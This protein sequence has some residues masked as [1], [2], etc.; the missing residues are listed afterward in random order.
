MTGEYGLQFRIS[1]RHVRRVLSFRKTR[2]L[3]CAP[4]EGLTTS[5]TSCDASQKAYVHF[6]EPNQVR[7]LLNNAL[8]MPSPVML[9]SC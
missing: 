2:E 4:K 8:P 6:I 3:G 7:S 5:L 1:V 9:L